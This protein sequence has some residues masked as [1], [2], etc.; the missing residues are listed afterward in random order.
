MAVAATLVLAVGPVAKTAA[1]QTRHAVLGQVVTTVT[2]TGEAAVV[3]KTL[4]TADVLL[5]LVSVL[6]IGMIFTGIHEAR[7]AKALQAYLRRVGLFT[8]LAAA[9][10][11]APVVYSWVFLAPL[12]SR[13]HQVAFIACASITSKCVNAQLVALMSGLLAFVDIHA[14]GIIV[15][16]AITVPTPTLVASNYVNTSVLAGIG[17]TFVNVRAFSQF[18]R[19]HITFVT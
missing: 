13:V 8:A 17:C 19:I 3:V 7:V 18:C 9:G 5:A 12:C 15:F 11:L 14:R 10:K 16:Q 1:G 4:L 6:A 2:G